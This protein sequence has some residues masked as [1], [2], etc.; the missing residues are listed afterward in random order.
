MSKHLWRGCS[1]PAPWPENTIGTLTSGLG[2][3]ICNVEVLEDSA[4]PAIAQLGEIDR[5]SEG[6]RFDPGSRHHLK[7]GRMQDLTHDRMS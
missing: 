3:R 7:C 6:P 4:S 1:Q 2:R 5:R